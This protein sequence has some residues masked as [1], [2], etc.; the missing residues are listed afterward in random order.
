MAS[1][2]DEVPAE[3]DRIGCH[4]ELGRHSSIGGGGEGVRKRERESVCG[5]YC[6]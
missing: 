4:Q 1:N 5:Q 6:T 2:L 3:S